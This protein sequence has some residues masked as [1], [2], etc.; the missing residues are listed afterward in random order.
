MGCPCCSVGSRL[1]VK[2][3]HF[4]STLDFISLS[5]LKALFLE[6]CFGVFVAL[7]AHKLLNTASNLRKK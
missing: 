1:D 7:S 5:S 2:V 3:G 4:F 6:V